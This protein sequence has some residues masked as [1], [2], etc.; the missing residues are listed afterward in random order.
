MVYLNGSV[1]NRYKERIEYLENLKASIG[2]EWYPTEKQIEDIDKELS[3]LRDTIACDD[4]L[5]EKDKKEALEEALE[6]Y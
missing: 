3:S 1:Y 4:Y 6:R 5:R 2:M